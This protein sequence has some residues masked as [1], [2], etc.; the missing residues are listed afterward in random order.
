MKLLTKGLVASFLFTGIF[1]ISG[2]PLQAQAQE[3]PKA[4]NHSVQGI[5][6]P[7][8]VVI[9]RPM[10]VG[11]ED[12]YVGITNVSYSGSAITVRIT[13]DRV[14]VK[15]V[16]PGKAIFSYRNTLGEMI[17]NNITVNR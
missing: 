7:Q 4:A 2:N 14:Y 8:A 5:F 9:N 12:Q 6:A 16:R 13:S 1:A 15:A 11:Q 10:R 3:F 17:I